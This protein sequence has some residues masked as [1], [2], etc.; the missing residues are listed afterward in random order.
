LELDF[1]DNGK[2]LIALQQLQ[3]DLSF[4]IEGYCNRERRHSTID[5]FSSIVYDQ[6]FV[7][8]PKRTPAWLRDLSTKPGESHASD[9]PRASPYFLRQ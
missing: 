7:S 1:D 2:E 8:A 9:E 4:W 5:Y 6:Q 3:R